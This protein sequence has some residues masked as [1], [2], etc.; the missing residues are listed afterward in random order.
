MLE[1]VDHWE[2]K[3]TVKIDEIEQNLFPTV[4]SVDAK[5]NGGE[6]ELILVTRIEGAPVRVKVRSD[7]TKTGLL[8]QRLREALSSPGPFG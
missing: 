1:G 6:T 8:I 3:M 2:C 4:D 5:N 7:R